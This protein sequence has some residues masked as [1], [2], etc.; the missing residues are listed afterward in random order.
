MLIVNRPILFFANAA[1]TLL[2]VAVVLPCRAAQWDVKEEKAACTE[3]DEGSYEELL[4]LRRS[5]VMVAFRRGTEKKHALGQY[6]WQPTL[7]Y[8][9]GYENLAPAIQFEFAHDLHKYLKGIH[10]A[11]PCVQKKLNYDFLPYNQQLDF[12]KQWWLKHEPTFGKMGPVAQDKF[13]YDALVDATNIYGVYARKF[14]DSPK[15]Q[16]FESIAV[17]R[18]VDK[19]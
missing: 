13:L 8:Q 15:Y 12:A 19:K 4:A 1:L 2:I 17:T 10:F 5:P 14:W 6:E 3:L 9:S 16:L 11:W 7:E 18:L